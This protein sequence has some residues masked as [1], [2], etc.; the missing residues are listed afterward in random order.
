MQNYEFLSNSQNKTLYNYIFFILCNVWMA[1]CKLLHKKAY[2]GV[3][4]NK[5]S[6][7]QQ[8]FGLDYFFGYFI[9]TYT[10]PENKNSTY[11]AS[12][13]LSVLIPNIL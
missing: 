2:F 4:T 6:E 5:F 1:I 8:G 11:L 9:Y 12:F 13:F 7:A 3:S 10:F